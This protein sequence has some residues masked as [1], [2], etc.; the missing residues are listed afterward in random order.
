MNLKAKQQKSNQDLKGKKIHF[1]GIGGIGMSALARYFNLHGSLIS[2]SDREDSSQITKLKSEGL[3]NIWITH[4]KKLIESTNPEVVVFSTAITNDNEE[5]VWAT[6]NKKLVLHRAELLEI[7]CHSKKLISV[8]GTHGKTTTTAL[9]YEV[10]EKVGLNPS[11]ILGGEIISKN[12]NVIFGTGNYF[13]IEADESDKS[14]LK[15]NPEITVITNIGIDHLENYNNRFE[16]IKQAFISFAKTGIQ[17]KGLVVCIEDL[18]TR[19]MILN[20]FDHNNQSLIT[21]GF[22]NGDLKPKVGGNFNENT[23]LLDIYLNSTLVDSIKLPFLGKHNILN[24]LAVYGVGILAGIN[25]TKIKWGIENFRGVKRRFELVGKIDGIIFIDDY[26]HHPTEISATLQAAR[27]LNPERLVVVLQPHQ[28]LR[29]KDLW[30][31]FIKTL[32]NIDDLVFVTDIY[33]ARGHPIEGITSKR[34]VEE[35]GKKNIEY[36]PGNIDEVKDCIKNTIK[37]GD[38]VLTLGAGD[39]TLLSKKL[40]DKSLCNKS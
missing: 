7:A 17:N 24:T 14:F 19:E 23:K 20:N 16:E 30:N 28:P 39:I 34:L 32:K 10:F 15:G 4:S 21:Y 11:C 3:N 31:D 25:P 13:I 27:G 35:V 1:I 29:L 26:A 40:M 36:L 8:S 2:G 9:I 18:N 38:L 33:I 5:L 6:S 37:A 12:S 22:Y